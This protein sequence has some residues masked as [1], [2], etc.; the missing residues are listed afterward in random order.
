MHMLESAMAF[1]VVMI[2]FSTIVTGLVEAVLRMITLRQR[3]LRRTLDLFLNDVVKKEL[4]TALNQ[5]Q[6]AVRTVDDAKV[7]I[8]DLAAE[9]TQNPIN[10][11]WA[12]PFASRLQKIDELTSYSFLQR[13]AKSKLSETIRQLDDDQL[14]NYLANI[15]RTYDRYMAASSE[16]YRKKSHIWTVAFALGLAFVFNVP[17]ARVYM[18]LMDNPETRAELINNADTA[19]DQNQQAEVALRQYWEEQGVI[20]EKAKDDDD[21]LLLEADRAVVE[22]KIDDLRATLESLRTD[23]GLPIG[24]SMWPYCAGGSEN[25]LAECSDEAKALRTNRDYAYWLFNVLLAGALIGLGGPFWAKVYTR[26][27]Q[28]A[29][30]PASGVRDNPELVGVEADGMADPKKAAQNPAAAFRIASGDVTV[31]IPPAPETGA[32]QTG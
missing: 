3:T 21:D 11:K 1:A 14:N 30:R 17:A 20:V 4:E 29:G 32:D 7:K 2:I 6:A 27:A 5:A 8:D 10:S 19:I 9:F 16:F 15:T 25:I 31:K 26:L 12:G 18:H 24:R 22:K 13:L 28:F 23:T